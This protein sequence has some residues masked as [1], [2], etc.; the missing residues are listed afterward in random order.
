MVGTWNMIGKAKG[1]DFMGKP[2]AI[3]NRKN[4]MISCWVC[5]AFV[6]AVYVLKGLLIG[7]QSTAVFNLAIFILFIVWVLIALFYTLQYWKWKKANS[8]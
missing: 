2:G 5:V 6:A 4:E 3:R 1:C 7:F 8:R